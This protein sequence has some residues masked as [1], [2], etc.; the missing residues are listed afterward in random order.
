MATL[1]RGTFCP[2]ESIEYKATQEGRKKCCS[3]LQTERQ[4]KY[5]ESICLTCCMTITIKLGDCDGGG[6]DP[7]LPQNADDPRTYGSSSVQDKSLSFTTSSYGGAIPKVFGADKLTGNVIWASKIR[8]VPVNGSRSYYMACDFAMGLCEGEINGI[9]RMWMGDKLILDRTANTDNSG[10]AQPNADGFVAGASVDLTETDGVMR[11]VNSSQRQ[12]KI[13]VFTGSEYQLPEQTMIT[14]EGADFTPGYRGLA[15][16]LFENF[17]IGGST[18]PNM[19]VELTSNTESTFP[20]LYGNPPSVPVT[21]N[22]LTGD[23]VL[24]DVTYDLLYTSARD[25]GGTLTP[26]SGTG[27]AH[28]DFNTL[29]LSD[30]VELTLTTPAIIDYKITRVLPS[31]GFLMVCSSI[32]NSGVLRVYN[33]FVGQFTDVLGPGGS[34][35]DHDLNAGLSKLWKGSQAFAL[36][37]SAYDGPI[38]VF[39]GVGIANSAIGFVIVDGEGQMEFVKNLGP[40]MTEQDARS[41][42]LTINPTEAAA[43][44]KFI[45]NVLTE[46]T[47]VFLLVQDVGGDATM[48]RVA[49]IRVGDSSGN[50]ALSDATYTEFDTILVDE[51]N[52]AGTAH[53]VCTVLVDPADKNLVVFVKPSGAEA[54][55]FKYSPFTGKIVW[56]TVAYGYETNQGAD[57]AYLANSTYGWIARGDGSI[58]SLNMKEGIVTQVEA[59]ASNQSLPVPTSFSQFYNGTENSVTYISATTNQ[60]LTKVFLERLT[61]STIELSDIVKILLGRVGLLPTDFDVTDVAGLTLN[62]YTITDKKSLRDAF[63]EL[64]QTFKFDL[65]ESNGRLKYLARGSG[66]AQTLTRLD[67]ADETESSWLTAI[68]ENDIARSRKITLTYRDLDR[69]YKDNVQSIILPNTGSTTFNAD[70]AIEVKVPVVLQA[71]A[72]KKLAEILLY[73]KLTYDTTYTGI[74]SPKWMTLDPGDVLNVTPTGDANDDFKI[75]IRRTSIGNDRSVRIEASHED[76]DIYSD[77]V[78]IFGSIGRFQ[79]S[80][81]PTVP[82]RIDPLCMTLPFRSEDEAKTNAAGYNL[83]VTFLNLKPNGTLK[84]DIGMVVNG[85]TPY[86]VPKPETFPTWGY[87]TQPCVERTSLYSTDYTSVLRVKMISQTG[88]TIAS[89]TFDNVLASDQCN[90]A[91]VDGELLQF[92]TATSIGDN[93][94]EFTGI[95]HAKFGTDARTGAAVAGSKFVLLG[96]NTGVL[97]TSSIRRVPVARTDPHLLVQ[98]FL[99]NPNPYQPNASSIVSASNLT[100]FPVADFQASYV[101][102]DAVITWQRRSR[103]GG[104]YPDDG[105]DAP[106][107]TETD[108]VYTMYLYRND[109]T[110]NSND[111]ATYL[112]KVS[113]TTNT[114]TYTAALQTTDGFDRLT[115]GLYI[116]VYQL[117][118]A[119]GFRT[120]VSRSILLPHA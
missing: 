32:G 17:I 37:S 59:L 71:T 78:D 9:L 113:L 66:A 16:V 31:T 40:V 51:L 1:P 24:V 107:V 3:R 26:P 75:R 118:S 54:L 43:S 82:P 41:C 2:I 98:F 39:M 84:Q 11:N 12:T 95:H 64:A 35:T 67:F 102:N 72:A 25:F 87:V 116:A 108:E 117:G 119:E 49:R 89:S 73:G 48:L 114:Y 69:E 6:T 34:V 80:V 60:R 101:V 65:V 57:N 14:A 21:F 22:D 105:S 97:D 115:E 23:V 109:G 88:A 33:P 61:R 8:R 46:G 42:V 53:D 83:F 52:G 10:I 100:A 47:W 106:P 58:Y 27:L 76:P 7:N 20:R 56:K 44:P 90:L 55:V 74:L 94:Y 5:C 13:S 85:T 45:D 36:F 62:G 63:S 103:Y 86:T 91:W 96:D 110:F 77:V 30:E 68:D 15:Y 70:A 18:I 104:E 29:V 81:F 38:D 50:E 28:F 19:F 92:I 93:V 99:K 111:P 4:E 112:R 120:G 79:E